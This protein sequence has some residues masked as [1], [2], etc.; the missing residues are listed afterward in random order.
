MF[1]LIDMKIAVVS[2]GLGHVSRGAE[3]WA[4]SLAIEL[5]KRGIDVTLFKGGGKEDRPFER[6]VPCLRRD[7]MLSRW[8]SLM[9]RHFF[10]RW[11]LGSPYGLEQVTFALNLIP[12]LL[13]QKFQ[14]VHT[15]DPWIALMIERKMK[16]SGVKVILAH[17]TEEDFSF[18]LNFQYVQELTQHYLDIDRRRGLP[19]GKKWFAISNFVDCEK[20]KPG[21]VAVARRRLN[22][23][24]DKFVILDVAAIKAV[25]KRIDYL[26]D[27]TAILK[28]EYPQIFFLVAGAVTNDTARLEQL[29]RS[30]L[31]A[32]ML[33]LKNIPSDEMPYVYQAADLFT[34]GAFYEMMPIAIL[35]SLSSGLPVIANKNTV[36]DWIIGDGG[37]TTDVHDKGAL[38][39]AIEEY[40]TNRKLYSEKSS[41]ARAQ[42]LANFEASKIVEQIIAMYKE[43]LKDG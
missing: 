28:K 31:G 27:E 36:F 26:I 14:I 23:P 12:I 2:S 43:V 42:A 18:L 11:G 4:E 39:S 15:Q 33:F 30:R 25:H 17:G 20:F 19:K 35:E 5:N 41:S 6:K 7:S 16:S 38:S 8:A 3:V 1:G 29:G 13:R 40:I 32:D 24:D 21:D 10:W 9:T 34:H 22:I 37:Q